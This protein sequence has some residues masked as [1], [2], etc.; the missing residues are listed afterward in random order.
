MTCSGSRIHVSDHACQR[1]AERLRLTP[2][3]VRARAHIVWSDKRYAPP[4]TGIMAKFVQGQSKLRGNIARVDGKY[5]WMFFETARGPFLATI[6]VA[7]RV[8]WLEQIRHEV[9][10]SRRTA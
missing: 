10:E 8:L 4:K 5:V 3:E 7:P 1:A 6:V 9:E 2:A